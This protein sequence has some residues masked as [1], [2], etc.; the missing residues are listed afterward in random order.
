MTLCAV[1]TVSYVI[2]IEA[3]FHQGRCL[4]TRPTFPE[5]IGMITSAHFLCYLLYTHYRATTTTVCVNVWASLSDLENTQAVRY[6]WANSGNSK[7]LLASLGIDSRNIVSWLLDFWI[8]YMVWIACSVYCS[9]LLNVA[10]HCVKYDSWT[11]W[12][13]EIWLSKKNQKK[14]PPWRGTFLNCIFIWRCPVVECTPRFS[15]PGAWFSIAEWSGFRFTSEYRLGLPV[16]AW[17]C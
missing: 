5:L 3:N 6:Q 1:E 13:Y 16:T 8:L 15:K 17:R 7:L 11:S 4:L 10:T 2:K 12:W 9:L 14:K